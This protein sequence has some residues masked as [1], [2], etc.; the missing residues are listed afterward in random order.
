VNKILV[1]GTSGFVGAALSSNLSN[2]GSIVIGAVRSQDNLSKILN[3]NLKI[4][5]VGNIDS[6]TDWSDPLNNAEYIIHCAGV[7][8]IK[9]IENDKLNECRLV[10]VEGTRNLALQAA[11]RG[12]KR[13]I[14]LSSIKVNG[15]QTFKSKNFKYN[16]IPMPVDAYAISKWEA[17][18]ILWEISARTGLEVV[19]IRA[20][21]IYGPGV[22]GNFLN[23]LN[24][25]AK[26]IP[27]P[28]LNIYNLRSFVGIDNLIDLIICCITSPRAPGNTFLV[29]DN[30]DVSTPDLINKIAKIMGKPHRLIP[31]P[32]F[33]LNFAGIILNKSS[34]IKRLTGSLQVDISNTIEKLGWKPSA[35]LDKNLCKMVKWY[36]NKR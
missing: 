20:P 28:L 23:L 13:F 10:N 25:I 26:K 31:F 11:S 32:I 4:Y 30:E 17:E 27:L 33:L 18:K 12:I 7:T 15:E 29:S 21:L 1:T 14:F 36:L 9:K 8:N 34:D 22:K 3:K 16:D 19:I 35:S 6:K 5:K 2:S 24:L